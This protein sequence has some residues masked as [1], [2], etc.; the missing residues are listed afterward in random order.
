MIVMHYLH[1][2]HIC[3]RDVKLE[4]ILLVTQSSASIDVRDCA[5]V[6]PSPISPSVEM[7]NSHTGATIRLAD[8]GLARPYAPDERLT[9]RCGSEEYASPQLL[10]G[11]RGYDPEKTDVWA[12]GCVLFAMLTGEMAFQTNE[13]ESTR[14]MYTKICT[15]AYTWPAGLAISEAAKRLVQR[16]LEPD[17]DRRANCIELLQHPW[18]QGTSD[19]ERL[20][21]R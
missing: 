19:E 14:R 4:N 2:H 21:S 18:L 12:L 16:C 5:V 6:P 11:E 17:E 13:G 9:T 10:C 1:R 7:F 15:G 8:F 3:H 20:P